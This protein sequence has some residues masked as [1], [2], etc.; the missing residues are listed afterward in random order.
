MGANIDFLIIRTFEK[1]LKPVRLN[2]IGL[3]VENDMNNII[4]LFYGQYLQDF[5]CKYP[6]SDIS[7]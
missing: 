2:L 3:S 6:E 4:A 5:I 1:H 7:S